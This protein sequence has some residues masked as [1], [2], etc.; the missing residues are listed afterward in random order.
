MQGFDT[1]ANSSKVLEERRDIYRQECSTAFEPLSK[2]TAYALLRGET[3]EEGVVN[4]L[5]EIGYDADSLPRLVFPVNELSLLALALLVI[6]LLVGGPLALF[7][8]PILPG[9]PPRSGSE[10]VGIFIVLAHGLTALL[11]VRVVQQ[12]PWFH[13]APGTFP[14]VLPAHG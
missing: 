2:L 3:T 6:F 8:F 12:T 11:T 1:Q 13:R 5:R 10:A 4:R 9:G 7:L 14:P